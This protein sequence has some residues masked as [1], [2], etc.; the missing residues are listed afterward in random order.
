MSAFEIS[1]IVCFVVTALSLA[2]MAYV[3]VS[4]R[5][6]I[7]ECANQFIEGLMSIDEKLGREQDQPKGE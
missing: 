2:F 3:L 4:I 5:G 6:A 1:V 7:V